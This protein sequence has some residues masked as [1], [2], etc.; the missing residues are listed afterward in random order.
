MKKLNKKGETIVETLVAILIVAVC[1][2]MLQNS[3]VSAARVNKKSEE[4][5]VPFVINEDVT[6]LPNCTI[7]V[8]RNSGNDSN[9]TNYTCKVTEGGYYYYEKNY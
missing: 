4:E 7:K 3:I 6:T 5:N 1:F 2:L 9:V 8:R